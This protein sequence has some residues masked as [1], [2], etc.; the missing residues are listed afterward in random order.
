MSLSLPPPAGCPGAKLKAM[1]AVFLGFAL[2][3][4]GCGTYPRG[5]V[6]PAQAQLLENSI[7]H[8]ASGLSREQEDRILALDPDHVTAAEVR[9]VLKG[10][11]APQLINIHGG[12]ASVI[13]YMVSFGDFLIGMG[14]P[15][16]SIRNAADGTYTFS[17]YE[18][19][20][21]IAGMIAWY[22]EKEGMRPMIVGHSQG[23]IQAVK[24][25]QKLA[26]P[27][28]E[29]LAVWNPLTW[30]RESR[31]QI[32]DPLTGKPRPVVGLILPYATAVGAGGL[33][34]I[35]PNQWDMTLDLRTIP[36]SVE[37]FTGFYKRADVLGGDLLGYGSVNLYT[38]SG[39]AVVRNI[40][41]PWTYNHRAIPDTKQLLQSQAIV[42]WIDRY[43]PANQ[44]PPE[45][46][47]DADSRNILWAADVWFSIKKHWVIELQRLIQ[48]QRAAA[49]VAGAEPARAN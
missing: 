38:A 35:V 31:D 27:P 2:L 34:R 3:S 40:R 49:S 12:F 19:S 23:G 37:E 5:G 14:Y 20:E 10:A 13:K 26:R 33:G 46:K 7:S 48:A 22:Y 18:D 1:S 11:P 28:S 45:P 17:C 42:D 21:M 24:I 43:R 39:T 9:T 4:N 16:S 25:L 44:A 29:P 15:E 30:Q 47:F 6:D 32:T 41:L 8:R 36:D